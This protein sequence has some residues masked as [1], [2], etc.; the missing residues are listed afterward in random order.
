MDKEFSRTLDQISRSSSW[1]IDGSEWVGRNQRCSGPKNGC[2][3]FRP[4]SSLAGFNFILL[5]CCQLSS[6][7]SV[8]PPDAWLP[9]RR[10]IVSSTMW[11]F[12]QAKLT[13]RPE[14]LLV[15]E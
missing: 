1:L 9:V 5:Q 14:D 12:M 7:K 3:L 15:V 4:P 2:C 13:R 8:L 6:D 11:A 10:Y